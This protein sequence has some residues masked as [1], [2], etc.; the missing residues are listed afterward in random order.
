VSSDPGGCTLLRILTQP[1]R[2]S[3]HEG[4]HLTAVCASAARYSSTNGRTGA[5]MSRSC[6]ACLTLLLEWEAS[7]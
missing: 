3:L 7:A 1:T 5:G 4:G 6:P 2:W